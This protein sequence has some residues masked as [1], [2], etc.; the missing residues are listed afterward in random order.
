MTLVTTWHALTEPRP[1]RLEV[2]LAGLHAVE[3][4]AW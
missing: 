4:G 3:P 1:L 2:V